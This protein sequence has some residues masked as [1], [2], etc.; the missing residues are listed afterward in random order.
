MTTRTS[1]L[2]SLAATS[3]SQEPAIYSATRPTETG[4]ALAK[5]IP[6]TNG[7][8]SHQIAGAA[9]LLTGFISRHELC[10][11][12][13]ISER[14]LQRFDQRRCGPPK[15]IVGNATWYR[16]TTVREWLAGRESGGPVR[17]R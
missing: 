2:T 17:R 10:R 5:H 6:L 1:R 8:P 15:I 14:S 13:G 12:L 16:V 4:F 11:A 9:E 3:P 7:A